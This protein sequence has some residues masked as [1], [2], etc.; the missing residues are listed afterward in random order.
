MT[1]EVTPS[2]AKFIRDSLCMRA[3]LIE[4]VLPD[5]ASV[6]ERTQLEGHLLLGADLT[7]RLNLILRIATTEI[8]S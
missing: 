6:E 4:S 1:I 3:R 5:S 2:E 8:A 7:T